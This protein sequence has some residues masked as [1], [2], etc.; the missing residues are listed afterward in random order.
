MLASRLWHESKGNPTP[1]SYVQWDLSQYLQ[2]Q[3]SHR[4]RIDA[5]EGHSCAELIVYSL[6]SNDTTVDNTQYQKVLTLVSL[7]TAKVPPSSIS[8]VFAH[9]KEFAI[10]V[11]LWLASL[12]TAAM[13]MP[14]RI[15]RETKA[16]PLAL[17]PTVWLWS[18]TRYKVV[19]M[20][21]SRQEGDYICKMGIYKQTM[22]SVVR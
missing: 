14:E 9:Q 2:C 12:H 21:H 6:M 1:R 7:S 22:S 18:H 16:L 13:Y 3:M 5:V 19:V 20:T 8:W 4:W 10:F 17:W 11:E 15:P